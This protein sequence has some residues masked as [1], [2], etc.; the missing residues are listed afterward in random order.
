M[1]TNITKTQINEIYSLFDKKISISEIVK[2][3]NISRNVVN[4]IL[5][6][7][8]KIIPLSAKKEDLYKNVVL[9]EFLKGKS[10]TQL[11]KEYK[12]ARGPLALRLKLDGYKVINHQNETKFNEK[13]F[14]EID[15]EEKAY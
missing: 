7:A 3:T 4:R 2:L 10:L 11:S 14:D 6:E 12:I 1:K 15:T 9:P 5:R 13:V 8:G